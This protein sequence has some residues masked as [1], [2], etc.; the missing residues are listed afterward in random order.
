MDLHTRQTLEE[1]C[2]ILMEEA[3][4][5]PKA[6]AGVTATLTALLDLPEGAAFSAADGRASIE[7]RRRGDIIEA[8][9]HCDSVS[10]LCRYL[11]TENTRRSERADSL[12][13]ELERSLGRQGAL[14]RELAALKSEASAS[15][16][17]APDRRWAWLLAGFAAGVAV[18]GLVRSAQN[19]E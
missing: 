14:S 19:K 15:R 7:L 9:G 5:I 1:A 11:R 3:H 12:S 6:Q 4:G 16:E 13:W 10:R 18:P 2:T 8:V 17:R